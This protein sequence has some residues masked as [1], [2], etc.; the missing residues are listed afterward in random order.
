MKD[1][2]YPCMSSALHLHFPNMWRYSSS[3]NVLPG[4]LDRC[5]LAVQA[6]SAEE[7]WFTSPSPFHCLCHT[8]PLLCECNYGVSFF[9]LPVFLLLFSSHCPLPVLAICATLFSFFV[10]FAIFPIPLAKPPFL[11]VLTYH[12]PSVSWKTFNISLSQQLVPGFLLFIHL[13]CKGIE[14]W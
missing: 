14:W 11:L 8:F 9:T 7:S 13:P 3:L 2:D 5:F 4:P 6:C 1:G 12:L 10:S